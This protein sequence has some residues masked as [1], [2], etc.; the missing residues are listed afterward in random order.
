MSNSL[1]DRETKQ[2][3][4]WDGAQRQL[5]TS[6]AHIYRQS[7]CP[8]WLWNLW[9]LGCLIGRP[10]PL[11]TSPANKRQEGTHASARGNPLGPVGLVQS[12]VAR[13]SPTTIE[14][15]INRRAPRHL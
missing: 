5:D 8:T 3:G 6:A 1:S 7:T 13:K 11:L 14:S 15:L 12:L 2:S 4:V 9:R 10:T